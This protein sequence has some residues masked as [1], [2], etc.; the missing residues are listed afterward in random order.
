MV[1]VRCASTKSD[2][3]LDAFFGG[4]EPLPKFVPLDPTHR[5]ARAC[6]QCDA[7]TW[8]ATEE[9]IYCGYDIVEHDVS[10]KA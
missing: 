2:R 9:C 3:V 10:V 4:L 5:T 8:V 7:H 6:T 1:G